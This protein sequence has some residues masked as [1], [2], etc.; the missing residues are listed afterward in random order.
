MNK[1]FQSEE[2]KEE[3]DLLRETFTD[4]QIQALLN[5]CNQMFFA[6]I[7]GNGVVGKSPVADLKQGKEEKRNV[8]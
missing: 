7:W 6:K 1:L 5:L 4:E 2:Y 3:L 8:V